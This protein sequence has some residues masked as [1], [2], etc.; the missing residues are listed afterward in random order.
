ME[1]EHIISA[2]KRKRAE[3]GG[4]VR[5]LDAKVKALRVSLIN[6]DATLKLFAPHVDPTSIAPKR[7][8]RR[9]LYFGHNELHR[10]TLGTLRVAGGP[11]A[12][13]DIAASIMR[14][15]GIEAN[16]RATQRMIA[17]RVASQ[18]REMLKRGAVVRTG[19]R[20]A[21]RWALPGRTE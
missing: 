10:L 17:G 8:N 19:E 6:I 20:N 3:I 14:A 7:T 2:L 1:N 16:D 21:A 11:I 12:A 15:K 9:S 4:Q 18:L 5:D 13:R